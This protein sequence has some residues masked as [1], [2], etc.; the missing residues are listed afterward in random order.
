[1]PTPSPAQSL[2][3]MASLVSIPGCG[4]AGAV[5]RHPG[6]SLELP[7]LPSPCGCYSRECV[8]EGADLGKRGFSFKLTSLLPHPLCACVGSFPCPV[9]FLD[10]TGFCVSI[11]SDP[12]PR[13]DTSSLWLPSWLLLLVSLS[14]GPSP[15]AILASLGHVPIRGISP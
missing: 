5:L 7:Q 1:M 10:L 8:S 11:Q 12:F 15:C 13:L 4:Q 2:S 3:L 6:L 9:P 14:T